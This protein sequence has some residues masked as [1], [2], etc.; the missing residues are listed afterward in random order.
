MGARRTAEPTGYF[1]AL[2]SPTCLAPFAE[3]SSGGLQPVTAVGLIRSSRSRTSGPLSWKRGPRLR[4][5]IR[6]RCSA[7]RT[8]IAFRSSSLLRWAVWRTVWREAAT[9]TTQASE[10]GRGLQ[11]VRPTSSRQAIIHMKTSTNSKQKTVVFN[12]WF[13]TEVFYFSRERSRE[14]CSKIACRYFF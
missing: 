14:G 10:R 11:I 13:P 2:L 6:G 7:S 12:W 5:A 1:P 4:L 3:A 9:K 8:T